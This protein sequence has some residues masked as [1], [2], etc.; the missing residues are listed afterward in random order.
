MDDNLEFRG[1]PVGQ[2]QVRAADAAPTPIV[3]YA[4]VFDQLSEDLRFFREK[5]PMS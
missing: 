3:G 1:F 2:I 4:A 5:S